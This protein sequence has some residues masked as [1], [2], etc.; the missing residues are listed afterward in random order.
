MLTPPARP[1][2]GAAQRR[3]TWV[4]GVATAAVLIACLVHL[5]GGGGTG[6]TAESV[7]GAP[8]GRRGAHAVAQT[9][10][11]AAL[12][13]PLPPKCD[14]P[15]PRKCDPPSEPKCDPPS[16]NGRPPISIKPTF[17]ASGTDKLSRHGYHRFYDQFLQPLY[18]T[19]VRMVEIGVLSG[20]SLHA[21]QTVFDAKRSNIYGVSWPPTEQ[22][23]SQ[24]D[25]NVHVLFRDQSNCEHLDEIASTVGAEPLHLVIDDGSHEPGHQLKTLVKLFPRVAPGGFYVIEDIETSYWDGNGASIYGYP[26][27]DVGVDA[28]GSIMPALRLLVEVLHQRY[29]VPG[30]AYDRD[31]HVIDAGVDPDVAWVMFA[32]N[33]VVI[34]RKGDDDRT[35]EVPIS[36][37]VSGSTWKAYWQS[38]RVRRIVDRAQQWKC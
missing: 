4:A 9:A 7:A 5:G 19:P 11:A 31:F 10:V 2:S 38:D 1:H 30:D 15:L 23:K 6:L 18:G 25:A 36:N 26:L 28:P 35:Y 8:G 17:A 33:M 12:P 3:W 32:Q 13:P 29:A 24:L 22:V 14:P 27:V 20:K 34:R 37:L 16:D 21:W